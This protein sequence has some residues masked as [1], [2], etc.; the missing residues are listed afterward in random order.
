MRRAAALRAA[1]R[2]ALG[3]ALAAACHRTPPAAAPSPTG[4]EV[5]RVV[6]RM[7]VAMEARDTAA[8]AS[9]L[10]PGLVIVSSRETAD[11]ATMVRRQTTPDF[12]R[13]VATTRDTLRE[14]V[15]SP[16]VHVDAGVATLW[17]PY[18]FHLGARFSHCG[19][20]AFTLVRAGGAWVVAGLSYTVRASPCVP[21][22]ASR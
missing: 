20:D 12:L 1:L 19:H 5:V 9:L 6:E 7:F 22:P 3:A 10:A 13:L 11:G 2:A 18:D 16:V 4:A 17:A 8:L 21:P 15:W 14:R